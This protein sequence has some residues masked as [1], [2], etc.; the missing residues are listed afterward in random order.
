[1]APWIKAQEAVIETSAIATGRF[2]ASYSTELGQV[3]PCSFPPSSAWTPS[4]PPCGYYAADPTIW[5]GAPWSKMG[6][7]IHQDHYYR[8]R[9]ETSP[10]GLTMVVLAEGDLDCDGVRSTFE[11][12]VTGHQDGGDCWVTGNLDVEAVDPYE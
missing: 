11:R 8:Y 2:K 6:F 7:G 4:A 10:D 12:V 1:V 5:N 3:L 9:I